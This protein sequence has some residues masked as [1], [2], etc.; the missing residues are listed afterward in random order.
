[1]EE[2]QAA[3]K[4][5]REGIKWMAGQ[6]SSQFKELDTRVARDVATE[7]EKID[8]EKEERKKR[9]AARKAERAREAAEAE[10][11]EEAK[12]DRKVV[13]TGL[14]RHHS[15]AALD[16]AQSPITWFAV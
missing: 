1:M 5:V 11:R 15:A 10:A 2:G 4:R 16:A 6:V 8:Q 14:A 9:V 12:S 3:D 13:R 7:K